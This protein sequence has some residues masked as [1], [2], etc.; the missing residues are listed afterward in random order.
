MREASVRTMDYVLSFGER[1]SNY[2]IANALTL[3][4]LPADYLDAREII[5][6]DKNFSAAKVDLGI[7]YKLPINKIPTFSLKILK[8]YFPHRNKR[9]QYFFSHS[10]YFDVNN[11]HST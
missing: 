5:V 4:G 2:I 11:K 6:T 1:N 7:T 8:T 10:G 3:H 9:F